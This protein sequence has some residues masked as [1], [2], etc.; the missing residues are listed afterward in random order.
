M[1]EDLIKKTMTRIVLTFAFVL[2]YIPL[3]FAVSSISDKEIAKCA[4][5]KGELARLDCFDGLAKDNNLFGKQMQQSSTNGKG[6][7]LVNTQIN[8]VDDSNTVTL[9][10]E[11][12][13]GKGILDDTV[14][15]IV[16]C[17]SNKTDLHINWHSY[18]GNEARVLTRIG[19]AKAQTSL[20]D[21]SPD[22]AGSFRKGPIGF[23]MEMMKSSRLVAQITPYNENPITAVFD[24]TGLSSAIKPLRETCSW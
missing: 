10:L 2:L 11:A 22:K 8:P 6:Q 4:A 13:S 1:K 15:L 9:Y 24:I 14:S 20:W 16:R 19:N 12:E 5:V 7:W 3:S 21:I 23:L 17:Q 18:L